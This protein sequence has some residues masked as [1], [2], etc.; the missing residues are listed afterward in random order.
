MEA[1]PKLAAEYEKNLADIPAACKRGESM[2]RSMTGN[3]VYEF[4]FY[5]DENGNMSAGSVSG[6]SEKR[7]MFERSGQKAK[8]QKEE[9]DKRIEERI[10]ASAEKKRQKRKLCIR[11]R[12]GLLETCRWIF[13]YRR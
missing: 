5:I 9:F 13:V 2:I 10:K 3:R 7:G 12:L 11:M 1:D 6:P 4:R 8:Q